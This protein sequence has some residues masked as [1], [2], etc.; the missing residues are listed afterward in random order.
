MNAATAARIW[1]VFTVRPR[2]EKRVAERLAAMDLDVL[3]PTRIA[4]HQWSDRKRRVSVPLFPGYVFARVDE[5]ERLDALATDGVVRTVGFG[6]VLAEVSDAEVTLLRG[7]AETPERVEAVAR[8]AFPPGAAVLLT[9]GPLKGVRGYVSGYPR[10][11]YLTVEVASV[12]QTVRIQV[13]AD[14]A[15]RPASGDDLPDTKRT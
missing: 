7:L 5:R 6:G 11:H 1:R 4:L 2:A 12:G 3:L 15:M 10:D 13:P 8:E 14:S 9:N